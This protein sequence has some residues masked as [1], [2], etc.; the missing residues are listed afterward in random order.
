MKSVYL[1][2]ILILTTMLVYLVYFSFSRSSDTE[3]I[4][5]NIQSLDNQLASIETSIDPLKSKLEGLEGSLKN[6]FMDKEIL[7]SDQ[8]N[9]GNMVSAS[10]VDIVNI[11]S[12]LDSLIVDNRSF[13]T[14]ALAIQNMRLELQKLEE[15]CLKPSKKSIFNMES[16]LGIISL[17]VGILGLGIAYR[18]ELRQV[19]SL[20]DQEINS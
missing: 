16:T 14:Q 9:K 17:I 4:G 19:K 10:R 13:I 11:Q 12:A 3:G 5:D 8:G 6:T 2:G 15:G 7:G 1:I 18:Q 20:Q